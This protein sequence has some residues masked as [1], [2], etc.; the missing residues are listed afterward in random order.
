MKR[1]SSLL[2]LSGLVALAVLGGRPL[3]AAGSD[4]S[5]RPY[6]RQR[7]VLRHLPGHVR[8]LSS[9]RYSKLT[10]QD[11]YATLAYDYTRFFAPLPADCAPKCIFPRSSTPDNAL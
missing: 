2:A 11:I 10:L 7:L 3:S 9:N 4:Y 6:A 8:I 5:S 1:L